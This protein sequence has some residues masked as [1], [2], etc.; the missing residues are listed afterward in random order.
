MMSIL[1]ANLSHPLSDTYT[2]PVATPFHFQELLWRLI[3]WTV[4]LMA[5]CLLVLLVSKARRRFRWA[6]QTN[7]LR[8]QAVIP[9]SYRAKLYFVQVE[10]QTVAVASDAGGLRTMILLSPVFADSL[11]HAAT[12]KPATS[13]S[14]ETSQGSL[15]VHPRGEDIPSSTGS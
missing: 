1:L 6:S 14:S 13:T 11:A 7:S 15:S 12:A 9:L 4:F 3:M 5:I 2:P 8:L 10:E